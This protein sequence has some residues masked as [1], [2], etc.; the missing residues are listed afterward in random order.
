MS[1]K[2]YLKH[3]ENDSII[4][5]HR[6][7]IRELHCICDNCIYRE[8]LDSGNG[9]I[10]CEK[11]NKRVN[12]FFKKKNRRNLRIRKHFCMFYKRDYLKPRWSQ[13][14]SK[15]SNLLRTLQIAFGLIPSPKINKITKIL[16][17][18]KM[19]INEEDGKA[20]KMEIIIEILECEEDLDKRF[21]EETIDRA[22]Q[23][24]LLYKPK[25]GYIIFTEKSKESNQDNIENEIKI[26]K[27]WNM[28]KRRRKSKR[29]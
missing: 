7:Q 4:P 20:I 27:Y 23:E 17:R 10:F 24:D 19:M 25:E 22:I 28:N 6:L 12:T 8:S 9:I 16:D 11:Q 5:L 14:Y 2:Y 29:K 21:I 3:Y 15:H 1:L 13:K 26:P 18:I